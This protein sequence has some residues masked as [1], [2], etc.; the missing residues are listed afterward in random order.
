MEYWRLQDLKIVWQ[1][2]VWVLQSGNVSMLFAS[3]DLQLQHLLMP[4]ASFVMVTKKG[5]NLCSFC[6][7]KEAHQK[8]K[9]WLNKKQKKKGVVKFCCYG[10]PA[11]ITTKIPNWRKSSGNLMFQHSV[12]C[13]YKAPGVFGSSESFPKQSLCIP[14][15]QTVASNTRYAVAI[16]LQ[17]LT[18]KAHSS[19][20]KPNP[21]ASLGICSYLCCDKQTLS[22]T[23]YIYSIRGD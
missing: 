15:Q 12:P 10:N 16:A 20:L 4:F 6:Q 18:C 2:C 21:A 22:Q 11:Y 3:W 7:I 1:Y 8:R 17:H 14:Q 5:I 9:F 19:L 13:E 23:C